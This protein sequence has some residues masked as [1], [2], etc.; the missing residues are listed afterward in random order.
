M[1]LLDSERKKGLE[2]SGGWECPTTNEIHDEIHERR[3][4]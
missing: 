4:A 3:G 2:L 1:L